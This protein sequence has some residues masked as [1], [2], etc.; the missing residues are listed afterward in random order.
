MI[1]FTKK[2]NHT[3]L[4]IL[5]VNSDKLEITNIEQRNIP[6]AILRDDTN[7]LACASLYSYVA[8]V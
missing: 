7:I 6:I 5:K 4:L 2:D 8:N 3:Y 1:L